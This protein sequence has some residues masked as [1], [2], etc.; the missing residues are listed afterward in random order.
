MFRELVPRRCR[1]LVPCRQVKKNASARSSTPRTTPIA[2]P[3]FA[4]LL[5]P[6]DDED[7]EV[8]EAADVDDEEDVF[9]IV[10]LKLEFVVDAVVPVVR[11]VVLDVTAPVIVL[12]ILAAERRICGAGAAKVSFVGFAQSVPVSEE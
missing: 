1:D 8:E 6:E 11:D 7:E 10:L 9:V 3:A 2:M 4:P 12:E 5:S